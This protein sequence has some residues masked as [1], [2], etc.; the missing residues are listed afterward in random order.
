M[1]PLPSIWQLAMYWTISIHL[2]IEPSSAP[3]PFSRES[4]V[5]FQ[6]IP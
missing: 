6:V 2:S 4:S 1:N 5:V 3:R